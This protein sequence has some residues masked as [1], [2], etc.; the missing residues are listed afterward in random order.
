MARFLYWT[1]SRMCSS[2]IVGVVGVVF[3]DGVFASR[4]AMVW[5]ILIV[6]R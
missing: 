3:G 6:F 5:A 2:V 1:A 4:S